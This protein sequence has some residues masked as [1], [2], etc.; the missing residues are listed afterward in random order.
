[1]K[2]FLTYSEAA[3]FSGFS[4]GTLRNLVSNKVLKRGIHY[5]KPHG[6]KILFIR[7]NFELWLLEK[8]I[9]KTIQLS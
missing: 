2:R 1:M 5:T 3:E 8:P 4:V 7:E 9:L 6:R